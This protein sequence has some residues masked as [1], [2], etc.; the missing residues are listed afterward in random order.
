MEKRRK[1]MNLRENDHIEAQQH[2]RRRL[3][4]SRKH[5]KTLRCFCEERSKRRNSQ[6]MRLWTVRTYWKFCSS[7]ANKYKQTSSR[8]SG[9]LFPQPTHLSARGARRVAPLRRRV[10]VQ[11]F[12]HFLL[13]LPPPIGHFGNGH[14]PVSVHVN[15]PLEFGGIFVG[16]VHVQIAE[17]RFQLANLQRRD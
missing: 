13:L 7:Q 12:V 2:A 14:D 11:L 17:G 3:Q 9:C 15:F 4:Q 5:T 8:F 1:R 10:F 6:K 16:N